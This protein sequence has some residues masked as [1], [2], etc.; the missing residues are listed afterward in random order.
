MFGHLYAEGENVVVTY[1]LQN[2]LPSNDYPNVFNVV[3]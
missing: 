3:V 1:L 2:Y